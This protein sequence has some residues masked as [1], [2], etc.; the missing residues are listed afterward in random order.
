MRHKKQLFELFESIARLNEKVWNNPKGSYDAEKAAALQ[1]E[2]SLEGGNSLEHL[3]RLV[4]PGAKEDEYIGDDPKTIARLIASAAFD[5][6]LSG[7]IEDVD[8]FDKHLDTIYIAIGELHKLGLNPDQMVDG[9]QIVHDANTQKS[10]EK[11]SEGKVIKPEGFIPP[12]EKLQK[13]LDKREF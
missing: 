8:A 4:T 7:Q 6:E 13:I 3:M 10:G 11:D 12:E 9:L 2:E 5:K 1:I